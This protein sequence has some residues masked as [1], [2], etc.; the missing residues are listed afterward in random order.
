ML[1]FGGF[2]GMF[3]LGG[4]KTVTPRPGDLPESSISVQIK[5]PTTSPPLPSNYY[6]W[7]T[8]SLVQA[9][10]DASRTHKGDL[11]RLSNAVAR[12]RG[13]QR[14]LR[15]AFI[16]GSFAAGAGVGKDITA[17]FP[18]QLMGLLKNRS[19][20]GLS[21]NGAFA[22]NLAQGASFQTVPLLC[23]E[24]VLKIAQGYHGAQ[25]QNQLPD[26]YI[27]EFIVNL[28]EQTPDTL[29]ALAGSLLH[30]PFRSNQSAVIL[31]AVMSNECL[32]KLKFSNPPDCWYEKPYEIH[33]EVARRLDLPLV[34]FFHGVA[35]ALGVSL[36]E[37]GLFPSGFEPEAATLTKAKAL[38]TELFSVKGRDLH[39]GRYGH[40]LFAEFLLG[41]FRD[42]AQIVVDKQTEEAISSTLP[43]TTT[44]LDRV[45]SFPWRAFNL[46]SR[47]ASSERSLKCRL[48][49]TQKSEPDLIPTKNEG[50]SLKVYSGPVQVGFAMETETGGRSDIKRAWAPAK[51]GSWLEFETQYGHA[52]EVCLLS[53]GT[54]QMDVRVELQGTNQTCKFTA[55]VP[56]LP[57]KMLYWMGCECRIPESLRGKNGTIKVVA[58]KGLAQIAGLAVF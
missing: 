35:P 20:S 4:F 57:E 51:E 3:G 25:Q 6:D 26:V 54:T 37:N 39:F 46:L 58:E 28:S 1:A 13:E 30:S 32:G 24:N 22:F 50:Y 31:A 47:L 15:V 29:L 16:G 10:M 7:D 48:T 12:A 8:L 49:L 34:S 42:A 21:G 43:P 19:E 14:P 9:G 56:G 44:D 36:Q 41:P 2:G 23:M 53:Y 38:M 45:L 52:E 27:V 11:T 18:Y 55:G 40:R 5:E 17:S 33:L